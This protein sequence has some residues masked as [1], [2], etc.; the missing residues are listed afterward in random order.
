MLKNVA[1]ALVALALA[2]GSE[3]AAAEGY[4]AEYQSYRLALG[5]GDRKG[6][7]AHALTAWKSAE[8]ELGDHKTSAVLA[9]NYGQHVLFEDSAAALPALR[10]AKALQDRGVGAAPEGDLDVYIAFAEF[11]TGGRKS[12]DARILREALGRREAAGR[13]PS[14]ETSAIWL[15]LAAYHVEGGR[16][17]EAEDAA[18]MASLA[19][20]VTAPNDAASQAAALMYGGVAKL[21]PTPRRVER[22]EASH[23][24]FRRAAAL[25]PPQKDIASVPAVLAQTA[26]WDVAAAAALRS[27]GRRAG[28]QAALERWDGEPAR[29]AFEGRP[30]KCDLQWSSRKPPAYPDDALEEGHFG[31]AVMGYNIDADGRVRDQR[32][33]A[34]VPGDGEFGKAALRSMESWTLADA[35]AVDPACRANLTANFVFMIDTPR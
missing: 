18:G 33:L 4:A 22:L 5:A 15:I 19:L 31:A 13:G 20:A 7:G 25:F 8:A 24:D 2:L 26:A 34:E 28:T 17:R 32:I 21:V 16:Y 23:Q 14:A 11:N 12:G 27:E 9:Y 1:P 30:Q 35:A 3:S 10:R 6:A 29:I